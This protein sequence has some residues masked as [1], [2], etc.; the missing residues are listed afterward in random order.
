MLCAYCGK[1]FTPAYKCSI[2]CSKECAKNAYNEKR[3][4]RRAIQRG[5]TEEEAEQ[6]AKEN[7]PK[8]II[9]ARFGCNNQ[10]F[11]K[12]NNQRYCSEHCAKVAKQ[13]HMRILRHN[14]KKYF[15][16]RMDKTAFVHRLSH[17][18]CYGH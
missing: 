7:V 18:L 1:E 4:K 17:D 15:A 5:F 12:T 16:Q 13:E 14:K 11:P 8:L 9:C 3:R 10:F 6:Y 2:Y